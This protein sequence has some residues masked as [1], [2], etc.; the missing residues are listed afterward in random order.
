MLEINY[1]ASELRSFNFA[2]Q[3][4]CIHTL[5]KTEHQGPTKIISQ[6]EMFLSRFANYMYST[7]ANDI[8]SKSGLS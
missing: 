2:V 6:Y 7:T 8:S 1:L 4:L 3:Y 5:C